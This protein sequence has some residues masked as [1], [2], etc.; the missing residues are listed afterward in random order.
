MKRTL[1]FITLFT[2]A[3]TSVVAAHGLPLRNS[4]QNFIVPKNPVA[5][6][7]QWMKNNGYC[8][9][10]SLI[11]AGM[12]QGQWMS[13]Y[14]A[15]LI[16]GTGLSQSGPDGFCAAN[17]G[18]SN[19][20]AQLLLENV[21]PGDARFASADLCLKNSRLAYQVYDYSKQ[22]KGIAG[23]QHFLSWVKAQVIAGNQVTIGVLSRGGEDPQYDHEVTVIKIGT[24]HSVTDSKYYDDDVLYFDDH[25]GDIQVNTFSTLAKTR[26]GANNTGSNYSIL[27]PG[28]SPIYSGSGGDGI[29]LNPHAIVGANYAFGVSGPSDPEKVTLPV[30]LSILSSTT[31]GNENNPDSLYGFNFENPS[32]ES[33]CTNKPP[34]RWMGLTLQV[35]VNGLTLGNSYRLYEY[36][37]DGISGVGAAAALKVPESNFNARAGEAS[38]VTSF[39][40]TSNSYT[41]TIKTTSDK[42]IVFRAVKADA[43]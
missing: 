3:F 2:S 8:G 13:Q 30:T 7:R 15:R 27:I 4:T 16:C 28:V 35:K 12:N 32:L 39:V 23:F 36:D 11:Q 1:F 31:N 37:F 33:S 18:E 20:N 9:E 24:Q 10:V 34:S 26:D 38:K 17:Q 25:H 43:P 21:N 40:A 19:Y 22:P 5:P 41:Q 14:N 6:F 42:V 29:H